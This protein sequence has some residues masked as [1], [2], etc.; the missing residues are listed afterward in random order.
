MIRGG[1]GTGM[2]AWGP[3]FSDEELQALLDYLWAFQ[4]SLQIGDER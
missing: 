3:I 1:M 4:F 2:P